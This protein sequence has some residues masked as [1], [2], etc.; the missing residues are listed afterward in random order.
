MPNFSTLTAYLTVSAV[1]SLSEMAHAESRGSLESFSHLQSDHKNTHDRSYAWNNDRLLLAF[2]DDFDD[3]PASLYLDEQED[4]TIKTKRDETASNPESGTATRDS[5]VEPHH[6]ES[7]PAKELS[8]FQEAAPETPEFVHLITEQGGGY[9]HSNPNWNQTGEMVG[10]EREDQ[11]NKELIISDVTGSVLQ[12]VKYKADED[13]LG[14]DMLLP[15]LV[16]QPSYNSGITWSPDGSRFV[17]MSNG[18]EGN[19]DL[20]LG[21]LHSEEKTRLTSHPEKDG[22]AH[23]SPAGDKLLFVS[24]RTG[25]ADV[26]LY[27]IANLTSTVITSGEKSYLYPQWSPDGNKIALVYGSN[28]N[29]DIL[30]ISDIQTPLESVHRVS[31]WAYD[32][33]RPIWSPDGT[34]LAFYTN[35]NKEGDQKKWA[36]AVVHMVTPDSYPLSDLHANI[37]ATDV[38]PD[39]DRGPAWLSNSREII[40][41]KRDRVRYNP[42][43]IVD[44]V[45]RTER[46]LLTNT[47]INHDLSCST[48]GMI[49]FRAQV[50]QWDHIFV[51]KLKSQE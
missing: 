5:L 13:D 25:K 42:I 50:E 23:W 40:Y 27:D 1:L 17:Y 2:S 19:Y 44:I 43:K 51:A 37:V 45:Q 3:L 39:M 20:Y 26:F 28:E 35:Y 41:V 32:D 10:F 11:R 34:K 14:L 30:L 48:D 4:T 15:G 9:N 36:I 47:R 38:V 49:A 33:L 12:T 46:M 7:G 16:D 18:S 24:G 31:D 8:A 21:A 22:H 29:H 6:I